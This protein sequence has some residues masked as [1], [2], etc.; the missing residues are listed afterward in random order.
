M[1]VSPVVA[2]LLTQVLGQYSL[3]TFLVE[4]FGIYAFAAYWVIKSQEIKETDAELRAIQGKLTRRVTPR[5]A[6]NEV[7]VVPSTE[8]PV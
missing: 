8:P 5:A 2:F 1:I 4:V 3:L 7:K 6:V